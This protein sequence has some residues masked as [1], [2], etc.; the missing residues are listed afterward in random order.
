MELYERI[1]FL[2]KENNETQGQLAKE[3]GIATRT[4]QDIEAGRYLPRHETFIAL[5]DHFGVSLDYLAGRTE[6]RET[7]R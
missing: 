7:A 5:A 2:R 1:R 3:V 6:V 4:Y